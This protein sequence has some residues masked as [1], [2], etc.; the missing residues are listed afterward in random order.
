MTPYEQIKL[1]YR[2]DPQERTFEHYLD[3]HFHFG[4]VFS[5][6]DFF[7]MGRAIKRYDLEETTQLGIDRFAQWERSEQDA[8][9]IHAMAGSMPEVWQIMPY[10]LPWIAWERTRSGKR[11]LTIVR[12][13]DLRRI[14]LPAQ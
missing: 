10:E 9:Y 11:E 13:N 2:V 1:K 5:R 7:A 3:W 8:W 6:P 4:F 14:S 12:T